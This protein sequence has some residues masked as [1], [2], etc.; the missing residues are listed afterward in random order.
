M[1]T[2]L[3]SELA[4]KV[5]IGERLSIDEGRALLEARDLIQLGMLASDARGRRH[6][7]RATFVRVCDVPLGDAAMAEL[8]LETAGELRLVGEPASREDAIE[9]VRALAARSGSVPVTGFALQTLYDLAGSDDALV[10]LLASLKA[11]GLAAVAEASADR[12]IARGAS[13][14][15]LVDAR[16]PLARLVVEQPV[17]A[18]GAPA[19]LAD[20]RGLQAESPVIRAVAPLA[21]QQPGD[22]PTTGFDDVRLVALA[23]LLLDNVESIQANWRRS[24]AKL[25]QVTLMFGVDDLDDVPARDP[26]DLGPRRS[27]LEEVRRNIRAASLEPAERNARFERLTR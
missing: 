25:A 3:L 21:R 18:A 24:G 10:G 4:A 22:V 8:P 1:A 14:A 19:W 13:L 20:L 26:R 15:P 27:S 5:A 16:M 23:R 2:E 12:I 17:E 6:G 9:A 7:A 11:A